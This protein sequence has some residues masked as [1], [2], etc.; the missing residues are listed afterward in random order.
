MAMNTDVQACLNAGELDQAIELLNAEV[1]KNPTDVNRRANLA[2]LLCIAGNL[3]R[4]D[5]ILDAI[6]NLDTSTAVGISLFRQ[7]IRAEQARQQFYA[8]GRV[9]EF[10]ATPDRILELELRAAVLMREGAISDAASVLEE[11]EGLR[12]PLAGVASQGPFDD[13][14]DLDDVSAGHLEI[15]T[16]T[17]KYFWIDLRNVVSIALRPIERRRDLLWRCADLSVAGGPDGAVFIPTI[18][19]AP[20]SSAEHRLGHTTE[21]RH[22]EAGAAQGLGLRTFLVGD[23]SATVLELDKVEFSSPTPLA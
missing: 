11:R 10:L 1:R 5:T 22:E 19:S 14:R 9:P 15:L 4:A 2:E 13:F 6:S 21:Y 16:T 12:A 18:Y 20:G 7:L 17:G 3:E 8:E 23:D